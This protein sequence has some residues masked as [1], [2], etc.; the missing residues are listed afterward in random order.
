MP[1]KPNVP[2]IQESER[3]PIPNQPAPKLI[4]INPAATV[5]KLVDQANKG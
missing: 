5:K 3:K 1:A 4:G 2:N